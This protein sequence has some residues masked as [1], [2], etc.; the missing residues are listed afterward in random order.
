[1]KI[2]LPN[3]LLDRFYIWYEPIGDWVNEPVYKLIRRIDVFYFFLGVA[4]AAYYYVIG[5]WTWAAVGTLT[6]ILG[7]MICIWMF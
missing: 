6:Y 7:L 3:K 4:I 1:M 5:G 2:P